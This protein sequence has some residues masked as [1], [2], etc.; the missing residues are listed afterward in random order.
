MFSWS[1]DAMSTKLARMMGDATMQRLREAGINHEISIQHVS[2]SGHG[3]V[4][5]RLVSRPVGLDSP[6]TRPHQVAGLSHGP[7]P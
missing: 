1:P 7:T 4:D 2:L 6:L 5:A 3:L